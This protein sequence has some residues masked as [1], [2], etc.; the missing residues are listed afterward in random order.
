MFTLSSGQ[1]IEAASSAT[2]ISYIISGAGRGIVSEGFINSRKHL[3][4]ATATSELSLLFANKNQNSDTTLYIWIE[5]S[6]MFKGTVSA[7]GSV[8]F[9]GHWR[10]YNPDGLQM[11]DSGASPNNYFP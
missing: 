1:T 11:L 6:L 3:Y 10:I 8:S 5:D 7:G 4:T 2:N 9:D